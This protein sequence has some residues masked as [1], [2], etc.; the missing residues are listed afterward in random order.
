MI[1]PF[2]NVVES[3]LVLFLLAKTFGSIVKLYTLESDA[4]K[5]SDISP[6]VLSIILQVLFEFGASGLN[7]KSHAMKNWK[8]TY[9]IIN[10]IIGICSKPEQNPFIFLS[11][12]LQVLFEFSNAARLFWGHFCSEL[13]TDL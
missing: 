9:N 8:R 6:I 13:E 5:K 10:K 2:I 12:I 4:K 1:Q 11:F 7:I 3:S